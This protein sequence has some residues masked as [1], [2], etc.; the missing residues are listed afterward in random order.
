M[1]ESIGPPARVVIKLRSAGLSGQALQERE[2]LGAEAL[3]VGLAHEV[4]G[5]PPG[6]APMIEGPEVV[7]EGLDLGCLPEEQL[8]EGV[9]DLQV[10]SLSSAR[11]LDIRETLPSPL[12]LKI[13]RAHV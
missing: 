2:Q 3:D 10:A 4:V 1:A 9:Q 8:S 5:P 7:E 11:H 13:G 12:Q 6:T